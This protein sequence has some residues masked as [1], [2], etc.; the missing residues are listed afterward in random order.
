VEE[1]RQHPAVIGLYG[2]W[3]VLTL[4]SFA[5][6]LVNLFVHARFLGSAFVVLMFLGLCSRTLF[7]AAI[8]FALKSADDERAKWAAFAGLVWLLISAAYL[9]FV[10]V[11]HFWA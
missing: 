6:L 7:Q 1:A 5:I 11:Y 10:V 2:A 3:A 8:F 9:A 4:S